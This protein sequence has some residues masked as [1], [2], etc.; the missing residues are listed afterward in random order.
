MRHLWRRSVEHEFLWRWPIRQAVRGAAR[1]G[2]ITQWMNG[3]ASQRG[4]QHR[5]AGGRRI[6]R[7]NVASLLR[8]LLRRSRLRAFLIPRLLANGYPC[9]CWRSQKGAVRSLRRRPK[10]GSC[11][12]LFD[13]IGLRGL[14]WQRRWLSF[15]RFVG[16]LYATRAGEKRKQGTRT[17]TRCLHRVGVQNCARALLIQPCL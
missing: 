7:I 3:A 9:C 2:R 1:R 15:F 5:W 16:P 12:Y 4:V 8:R 11:V 17:T 14:I 6:R 10:R 13:R